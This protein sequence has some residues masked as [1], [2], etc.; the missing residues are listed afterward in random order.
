VR[1]YASWPSLLWPVVA[2]T[3]CLL[4]IVVWRLE[5]V[6]DHDREEAVADPAERRRVVLE[7]QAR[8][9]EH[10]G[11]ITMEMPDALMREHLA[12]RLEGN[13][14]ADVGATLII[15]KLDLPVQ[16]RPDHMTERRDAIDRRDV[17][18]QRHPDAAD[19]LDRRNAGDE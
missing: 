1:D 2:L 8:T 14:H 11:D 5:P 3:V 16:R 17:P 18:I 4:P 13:P 12:S 10:A 9:P 15:P 19:R 7:R 6:L